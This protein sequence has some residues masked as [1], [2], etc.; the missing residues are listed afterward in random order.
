MQKFKELSQHKQI[1]ECDFE[2]SMNKV[3][4]TVEAY[5]KQYGVKPVV[6]VDYL[7]L[8]Q[9]NNPKLTNTK[10]IV[11]ANVRALKL[12]QMRNNLV[13]FVVSSLNRQN[14]MQ[15]IDF[16]SFKESGGIEY[17]ADCVMGLQL[18]VMNSGIFETDT[19]TGEK[20]KVVKAAKKHK[21][22]YLE[23]CILKNRYGI[24]NE[25]FYFQYYPQW[26]LFSPTTKDITQEV[27]KELIEKIK[28]KSKTKEAK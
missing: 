3:T 13:M 10:D 17:T 21:P 12:L 20:R 28:G 25:S 2:T 27:M 6:F 22:R 24:C 14:Y 5:I 11:D 1:I 9:S 4:N 8:I 23:L 18:S 19:K 15:V 7:Q 16:E 26:D